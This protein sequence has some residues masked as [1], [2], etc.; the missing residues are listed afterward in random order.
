MNDGK[1]QKA[2]DRSKRVL[3]RAEQYT[4]EQVIDRKR[5][6]SNLYSYAGNAHLELGQYEPALKHHKH[7]HDISTK[8]Y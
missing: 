5:L 4:D 3:T 1:H 6:I 7:D 8:G 2:L